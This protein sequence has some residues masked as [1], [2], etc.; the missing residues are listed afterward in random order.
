V[1]QGGGGGPGWAGPPAGAGGGGAG[2]GRPPPLLLDIEADPVLAGTK[3]IA[4][5]WDAAGLYQVATFAGDRWAVW[6]GAYRDRVR[7]FVKGDRGSV[8]ALADGLGGS[9]GLFHRPGR[10][11]LRSVNFV[12]CHDGL[13]LNDLGSFGA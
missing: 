5:A 2:P 11:P 12:T 13:H 10:G 8:A 7:R 4:E 1:E 3:M 6:N 9:A